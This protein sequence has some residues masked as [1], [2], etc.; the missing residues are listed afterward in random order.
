MLT[1]AFVLLAPT[2][3]PPIDPGLAARYLAHAR[4][5]AQ[6]DGGRLWGRSLDGPLLFVDRAT[7]TVAA[8][9]PDTEGRLTRQGAIWVGELPP[10]QDVANTAVTWAGRRWTMILWPLSSHRVERGRLLAHE[11][12]HRIQPEIG[13]TGGEAPNAHL[14]T[15]DGRLWTRLEWRALGEALMRRGGAR[16]AALLDALAYRARRRSLFPAAARE[17][18]L[19]ELNEGL[20]E[21]T[22]FVLG[23]PEDAVADRAA[24][25]LQGADGQAHFARSFAYATGPAYGVLLD[26]AAPSWK[27]SLTA[28]SD[29]GELARRAYRIAVPDPSTVDERRAGYDAE[30]VI[31]DEDARAARRAAQVAAFERRFVEG[32]V[33][34]L[35]PDEGL[36]YSFDPNAVAPFRDGSVFETARITAAWGILTVTTGG[37]YV[38]RTGAGG[39]TRLVV[40]VDPA[41]TPP[42]AGDGWTLEL[43][44]G[45]APVAGTR[46]GDWA[47]V[48]TP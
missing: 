40:P 30:R 1:L 48:R 3:A 10:G 45:W 14:A 44:P 11:M 20:A 18:Q 46:P 23:F 24:V 27:T 16:R 35:P 9:I 39:I 17:E 28:S 6:A 5:L 21:Y 13:L 31:A 4:E 36:Q 8:N 7:R 47:L 26:A 19:Q 33:L 25:Q 12:Y 41:R 22:G 37:V 2:G 29:L 15:R 34:V 42:V 43:A 32:P 38:E